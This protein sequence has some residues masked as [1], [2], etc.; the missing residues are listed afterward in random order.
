MRLLLILLPLPFFS[1]AQGIHF[2]TGNWKA[3]LAKAKKENRLVYMDMYATWC[4]PCQVLAKNI[5]P[6]K[7]ENLRRQKS[8]VR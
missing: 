1:S 8:D 4:A 3:V 5:F 7:M 6:L 2:E